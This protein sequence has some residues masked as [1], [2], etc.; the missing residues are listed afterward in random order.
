[1]Q[2]REEALKSYQ[3][4][5]SYSQQAMET[6]ANAASINARYDQQ[7]VEWL[8]A[9]PADNTGGHIGQ[10]EAANMIARR[11][12]EASAWA[13]KFMVQQGLMPSMA[14]STNPIAIKAGYQSETRHQAHTPS[15]GSLDTVR[16]QG[17]SAFNNALSTEGSTL[18]NDVSK[19]QKFIK[20]DIEDNSEDITHRGVV[21][22][23]KH[24]AQQGKSVVVKTV[25]KFD[26]ETYKT[27]HGEP[28]QK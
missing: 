9:Q 7:F 1:M 18:R 11:P 23:Q 14:T 8:A 16:Q 22:E 12:Q 28:Q 21:A 2:Q 13:N 26:L 4:A 25:D 5:E 19:A 3:E 27:I 17:S 20:E 15:E 6:R 10:R 24:K